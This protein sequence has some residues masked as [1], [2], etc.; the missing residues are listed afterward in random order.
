LADSPNPDIDREIIQKEGYYQ[1]VAYF[2]IQSDYEEASDVRY[3]RRYDVS[4]GG[5][6]IADFICPICECSFMKD[7]CPHYMPTD[8]IGQMIT[9]DEMN[10]IAPYYIRGQFTDAVEISFVVEGNCPQASIISNDM[11]NLL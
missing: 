11:L 1:L 5:M 8:S 6:S 2:A 3:G 4:I 10:L 9:R 7:S